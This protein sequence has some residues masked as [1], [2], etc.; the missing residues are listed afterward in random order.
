MNDQEINRLIN[1]FYEG[2]TSE[3]EEKLLRALFSGD[4]VPQGLET[5]R[6]YILYC[7]ANGSIK[8]PSSDLEDKI[9]RIIDRSDTE[10][11]RSRKY[12]LL[13][14]SGA[15]A[16]LILFGAYYFIESRRGFKDTYSDPRIAYA[17]T[18]KILMDVSSRLNKGT[19]ALRPVG[20][21]SEM[22]DMSLEKLNETSSAINQSIMKLNILKKVASEKSNRDTGTINK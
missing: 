13:L 21:L 3:E 9:I 7:L 20:K 6:E 22:T 8:D 19:S 10:S 17:E 5:E 2:E 12:Y 1:S 4:K 14:I 16:L 15:A 18:M 11:V